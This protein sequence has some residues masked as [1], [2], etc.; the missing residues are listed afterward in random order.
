MPTFAN[1][2]VTHPRVNANFINE[3]WSKKLNSKFYTSSVFG[4]IANRKWEGEIK[5][6]GSKVIIRTRPDVSIFDYAPGGANNQGGANNTNPINYQQ[7]TSPRVELLIDRAKAFAF[8]IDDIEKAQSDIDYINEASADAA[9]NSKIAIDRDVL[10]SI[11]AG[12]ASTID[13]GGTPLTLVSGVPAAGNA[14]ERNVLDWIV[15]AG[16]QLDALNVPSEGR[17]IVIPPSVAGLIKKSDLKDASITGDGT[18]ILRNGRLGMIDR[19]T[20]YVSNN[21]TRTTGGTPATHCIAGTKDF[22]AFASQFT[23]VETIRLGSR[24]ASAMRGL[25]VFGFSV[26]KPEAGVHLP[27]T[28]A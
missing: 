26:V 18:S 13:N 16:V 24:F 23:E 22:V 8:E 19:F 20:L 17:W 2:G 14:N 28:N 10:G 1:L 7:L 25:N 9:E 5:G 15:D 21:L 27:I 11:Y 3:I 6:Q 12:A 4:E